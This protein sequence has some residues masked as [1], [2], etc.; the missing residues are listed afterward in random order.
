VSDDVDTF[1]CPTCVA[2]V[3]SML[4]MRDAAHV[5]MVASDAEKIRSA[6]VAMTARAEKAE[7][8][9][10][11]CTDDDDLAKALAKLG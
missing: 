11:I 9:L 1:V 8:A 7:E 4:D 10:R 2:T 5:T 3:D 6:L